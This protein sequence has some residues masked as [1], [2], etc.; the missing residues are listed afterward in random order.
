MMET[1]VLIAAA[2]ALSTCTFAYAGDDDA[3]VADFYADGGGRARD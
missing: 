3:K 2:G 1:A